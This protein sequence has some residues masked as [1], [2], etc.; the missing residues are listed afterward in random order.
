MDDEEERLMNAIAI[1]R[2]Q[3]ILRLDAFPLVLRD[4]EIGCRVGGTVAGPHLLVAGLSPLSEVIFARLLSIPT[5]GWMRGQLTLIN[6]SKLAHIGADLDAI[7]AVGSHPDE[8]MFLPY[9]P[10]PLHSEQVEKE[11][12]W[13]VLRFCTQLGMISGRGVPVPTTGLEP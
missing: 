9:D 12:F 1:Q 13:T 8:V 10:D 2:N 6:L 4:L 11:G 5:L 7:N 3:D